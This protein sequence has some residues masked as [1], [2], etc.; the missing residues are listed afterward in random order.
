MLDC[1]AY[2]FPYLRTTEVVIDT[3]VMDTTVMDTTDMTS[4]SG[5]RNEISFSANIYPNPTSNILN[6]QIENPERAN[7]RVSISNILGQVLQTNKISEA[8][9]VIDTNFNISNLSPGIYFVEIDD[10]RHKISL[11]FLIE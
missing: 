1:D 3:T 5:I 6:V 8:D 7:L 4:I 2:V 11:N 9:T 10:E